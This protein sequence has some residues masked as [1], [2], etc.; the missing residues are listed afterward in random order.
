VFV[1]VC[2]CVRVSECVCECVCTC[3]C[4]CVYASARLRQKLNK[5]FYIINSYAVTSFL[6]EVV[7]NY[8]KVLLI[9]LVQVVAHV[10]ARVL[11]HPTI[12]LLCCYA[13]ES[14]L[15]AFLV[16]H[17]CVDLH[18]THAHT[19]CVALYL[20]HTHVCSSIF[21]KHDTRICVAPTLD[22]RT[23]IRVALYPH[24]HGSIHTWD[25]PH[26]H[27]THRHGSIHIY[28]GLSIYMGPIHTV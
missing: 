5:D 21:D 19:H 16:P 24:I 11:W 10:M 18:S 3:E 8:E 20:T 2:V 7:T 6:L 14:Q 17:I 15:C 23:H 22:T 13:G 4:V 12:T 9:H 25:R 1:C 26:I 27:G 28:M